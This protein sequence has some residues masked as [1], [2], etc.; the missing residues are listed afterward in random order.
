M[1]WSALNETIS[2]LPWALRDQVET[3]TRSVDD[4][5]P[6]IFAEAEIELTPARRDQI[7]FIAG[8]RKLWHLVDAQYELLTSSLSLVRGYGVGELQTGGRTY[9]QESASL[10]ALR[11]LRNGLYAELIR[12]EVF[13]LVN[14]ASLGDVAVRLA[15]DDQ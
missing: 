1:G 12:L 2:A 11:G 8:V 3:Y 7:I 13:N 10:D 4:A 5:V 9:S 14:T 6:E 15:D